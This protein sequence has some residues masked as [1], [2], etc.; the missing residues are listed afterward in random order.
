MDIVYVMHYAIG[1]DIYA[2]KYKV[3]RIIHVWI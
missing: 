2:E 3:C 1:F